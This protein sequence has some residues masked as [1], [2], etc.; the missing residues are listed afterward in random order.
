MGGEGQVVIQSL[1][2][3]KVLLLSLNLG[4]VDGGRGDPVSDGPYTK[5]T[6]YNKVGVFVRKKRS[7]IAVVLI[8]RNL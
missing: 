1:L 8:K 5:S 3:E 6:F 4:K 2:K 7:A